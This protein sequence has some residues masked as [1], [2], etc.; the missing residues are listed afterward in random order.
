M[1][2][3]ILRKDE[4][5]VK[6]AQELKQDPTIISVYI[7]SCNIGTEGVI[8]IANILETNTNVVHLSIINDNVKKEG[9][10]A[11]GKMIKNNNTMTSLNITNITK[12]E[13]GIQPIIDG[14][15]NNT[16]IKSLNLSNNYIYNLNYCSLSNILKTNNTLEKLYLAN[17]VSYEGLDGMRFLLSLLKYNTTL[18]ELDLSDNYFDDDIIVNELQSSLLESS[19]NIVRIYNSNITSI[20]LDAVYNILNCNKKIKEIVF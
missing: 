9:I 20:G 5:L 19:L 16:T 14:L 6:F 11:L 17:T 12:F 8:I 4:N 10:T 7:D 18:C 3:L 15:K 2:H 13:S 1:T